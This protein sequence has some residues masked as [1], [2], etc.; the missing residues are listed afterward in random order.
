MRFANYRNQ[1]LILGNEPII[2]GL[3]P[4]SLKEFEELVRSINQEFNLRV[5][6]TPVCDPEND[7]PFALTGKKSEISG[8]II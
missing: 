3:E 2:E 5:T 1:G 8:N 4:H 6:G 7:S